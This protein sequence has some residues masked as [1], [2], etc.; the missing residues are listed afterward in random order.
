MPGAAMPTREGMTWVSAAVAALVLAPTTVPSSVSM[1]MPFFTSCKGC[2]IVKARQCNAYSRPESNVMMLGGS[3]VRER[4]TASYL[5]AH[6]RDVHA[7][8]RGDSQQRDKAAHHT[9]RQCGA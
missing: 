4:S 6:Q 1:L 8:G 3:P 7:V 2:T 9:G 5:L